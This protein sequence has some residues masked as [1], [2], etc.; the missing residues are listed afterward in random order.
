MSLLSRNPI[1]TGIIVAVMAVVL[2]ELF[3]P[4]V[5]I[6]SLIVAAILGAIAAI[7]LRAMATG[8]NPEQ[9]VREATTQAA[10]VVREPDTRVKERRANEQLFRASQSF[11]LSGAAPQLVPT[12]QEIV[13]PLRA[14][15]SR[16]LEFAPG[17]ETTFNL[18]KLASEDL[19]VQLGNFVDLSE[20]DRNERTED[21]K[22]Q[23]TQLREKIQELTGFIDSG[24]EADFDAQATFINMK[25]GS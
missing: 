15:V 25:F 19:P 20:Q 3:F 18:V 17:S 21:L 13:E 24:R 8:E 12:L 10:E 11:I 9:A 5:F 2:I 7:T 22:N 23:L 6:M 14:V 16:A 1:V 4:L